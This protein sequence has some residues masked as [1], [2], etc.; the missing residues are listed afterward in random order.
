L[1][2][3]AEEHAVGGKGEILKFGFKLAELDLERRLANET[4]YLQNLVERR[5][6]IMALEGWDAAGMSGAIRCLVEKLDPRW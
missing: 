2:S 1:Q 6:G 5:R 4:S 3:R